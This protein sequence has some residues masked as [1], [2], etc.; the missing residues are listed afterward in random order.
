MYHYYQAYADLT[1]PV[2]MLAANAERILTTWGSNVTASPI[3]RMAAYYELVTL[4]GFTHARPDYGIK[5]VNVRGETKMVSETVVLDTDFCS[6]LRFTRKGGEDAPKVLLLA[7]M[8]GHFATLLRGTVRTLLKDYQVYLS[9]WKNVRDI[10]L[11]AGPFDLDDF[12]EHII[13]FIKFLGPQLHVMAVCQPTVPALA[14]VALM[15]QDKDPDQPASLTLMAG[16]IDTRI[17]PTVVNKLATD[18]PIEWF[19]E[20]LVGI[21]PGSLKGSGRLVY[22]GFLQ[23]AAFMSMNLE[24]HAKSF[25]D[26]FK[27]RLE[28]EFEKADTI[29]DFYKEYFAIMDLSGEFYLQTIKSVFQ[30]AAL[31]QGQLSYRGRLIEPQAIK[32]TFLLTVEGERDDICAIGQTLAAHDLCSGLRPYMKSH[33]MEPG[34]GHYGVFNGKRWDNRI[35]PKVRDHIQG[36]V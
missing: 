2:R 20:K 15:A 17:S 10:P 7:P 33:H 21:V 3:K 35:Y 8:S 13:R 24:R 23:L 29:R 19:R 22:P 18:H 12:I 1:D 11:A 25:A 16:P 28:G 4:A 9:D 30:D 14:A 5:T 27:H 32:R 6:L 36:S 31:A 34:A 26:L